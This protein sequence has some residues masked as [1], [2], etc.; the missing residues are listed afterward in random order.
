MLHLFYNRKQ[1]KIWDWIWYNWNITILFDLYTGNSTTFYINNFAM[2][3]LNFNLVLFK[4]F[5]KKNKHRTL[6]TFFNSTSSMALL[7]RSLFALN[8]IFLFLYSFPFSYDWQR[9]LYGYCSVNGAKT[10]EHY[11]III[12][13]KLVF[14]SLTKGVHLRSFE[15]SVFR[16]I[17]N[18]EHWIRMNKE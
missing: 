14:I 8:I 15:G 3:I 13:C 1:Y 17:R 9:C 12:L 4:Y 10:L 7:I 11:I 6:Y 2:Y 18:G 16:E 5:F